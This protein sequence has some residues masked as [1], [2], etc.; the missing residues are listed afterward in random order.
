MFDVTDVLQKKNTELLYQYE[1]TSKLKNREINIYLD[2][3]SKKN[4][5]ESAIIQRLCRQLAS[6]SSNACVYA[7]SPIAAFRNDAF[8]HARPNYRA[9]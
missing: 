6:I 9:A 1:L 2:V 3:C 5:V 7:T 8:S 4:M